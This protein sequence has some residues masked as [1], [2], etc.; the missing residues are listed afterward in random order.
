MGLELRICNPLGLGNLH[1]KRGSLRPSTRE[2]SATLPLKISRIVI[3]LEPMWNYTTVFQKNQIYFHEKVPKSAF[4][5]NLDAQYLGIW[6]N[7]L[8]IG[9]VYE[10]CSD[11]PL[12]QCKYRLEYGDAIEMPK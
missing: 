5:F 1:N 2:K 6:V 8:G 12:K 4:R 11:N 3:L 9:H 10:G 7:F